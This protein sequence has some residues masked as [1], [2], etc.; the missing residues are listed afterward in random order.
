[1]PMRGQV[2]GAGPVAG[3]RPRLLKRKCV[4]S[5]PV[6]LCGVLFPAKKKKLVF[7]SFFLFFQGINS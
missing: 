1:M 7:F 6:V 2:Q 5:I 3:P 4:L